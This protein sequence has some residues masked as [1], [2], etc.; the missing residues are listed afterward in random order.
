MSKISEREP[1]YIV[2]VG[3]ASSLILLF[4]HKIYYYDVAT[5]DDTEVFLVNMTYW[6]NIIINS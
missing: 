1:A 4:S 2:K 6:L 3:F 5:K